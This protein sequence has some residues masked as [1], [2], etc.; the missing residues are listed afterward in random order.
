MLVAF[1]LSDSSPPFPTLQLSNKTINVLK[2]GPDLF[3]TKKLPF[4]LANVS[5]TN[6]YVELQS[7]F[8]VEKKKLSRGLN[9]L[10]DFSTKLVEANFGEKIER[11]LKIAF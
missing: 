11:F 5:A 4:S 1:A 10:A 9:S 7:H 8:T 6:D 2:I 3:R